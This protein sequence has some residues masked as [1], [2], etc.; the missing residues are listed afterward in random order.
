M[1]ARLATLLGRLERA[2]PRARPAL[3]RTLLARGDPWEA[4][5]APLDRLHTRAPERELALARVLEAEARRAHDRP[6]AARFALVGARALHRAGAPREAARALGRAARL[7]ARSGEEGLALKAR[8]LGVDALA[9]A[10]RVADALAEAR[11][12]R[13]R[14]GGR[15]RR[16]W[17]A[18]LAVNE[19]AALRLGGRVGEARQGFERAARAFDALGD[20]HSA[21]IARTNA[22][23]ACLDAGDG[24]GARRRLGRAIAAF[25]A[26]GQPDMLLDARENLC[27]AQALEGAL[28]EAIRGL[29][30]LVAEQ[31]RRGL[32]RRAA[33]ARMDLADVLRRAGDRRAAARSARRAA[34]ELRRL[35]ARAEEVE[36]LWQ[37][38][39]AE[40]DA[41]V[42]RRLRARARRAARRAARPGIALRCELLELDAALA[43]GRPP[44]AAA[45]THLGA[46]ARRA[47][48]E[49]LAREAEVLLGQV[50]WA[51]GRAGAAAQAWRAALRGAAGRPWIRAAAET[52]LALVAAGRG[53]TG[54]AL[55]RLRRVARFLDAVRH[56]LPGPWLR[57]AFVLQQ[58]DP[59]LLRVDLLLDRGRPAD[60]REAAALLGALGARR[61]LERVRPAPVGPEAA[62]RRRLEAIYD[63]L[64][65]GEGP[66]RGLAGAERARLV[67]EARALE[68]RVADAWRGAERAQ[69]G[70]RGVGLARPRRRRPAPGT[71][72]LHLW[73]RHGEVRGLW[74]RRERIGRPVGLGAARGLGEA[75][76]RVD[77]HAERLRLL[78]A[79]ADP[80]PLGAE[81]GA[82]AARWLPGLDAGN[83]PRRVH[84]ARDPGVPDLPLE[85]LPGPAGPL[86]LCHDLLRVPAPALGAGRALAARGVCVVAL[87]EADL[88]ALVRELGA[89]RGPVER[90]EGAGAT[91]AALQAA[92]RTRAVVHVAGHGL[93]APEAPPLGGIRV[94]DG[95]FAAADVPARVGARLVVLSACRTGLEQGAAGEAWGGLPAALL[96]AG[97][98]RVLYTTAEVDD[99]AAARL[100]VA[101][102]A[103]RAGRTAERAFGGAL[104]EV[105][106]R[107]GHPGR[108]LPFR[109]A[110]V[111]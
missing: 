39:Q 20:R 36:A 97:A 13:P 91:R 92:L 16:A 54:A 65:R 66:L 108:L 83:W 9:H 50:A 23:V 93:D 53:E 90:I 15:T 81:L 99:D 21:A 14:L 107:D 87:G 40:P 82:L 48:E 70:A 51:A 38:A 88:P 2:T 47:G 3:A 35:G 63:R 75:L 28:G 72:V 106:G 44:P 101:F 77:F 84:V 56:D 57:T 104:A 49:G 74:E 68:R 111:A 80:A 60:R 52:G 25:E 61:F 85:L 110:G 109:L 59:H 31:E 58:L 45:L 6:L 4:W 71:L 96:A 26:L 62:L 76:E 18:A 30:G 19:A 17:R 10:G 46:R 67:R 55:A 100:A 64:A 5:Q 24:A 102:H 8:V 7:L 37:A 73:L 79:R 22:A 42:R 12:L 1:A 11:R 33:S 89:V 69:A 86:A 95:W 43:A 103:R 94:S 105:A 78:G 27:C 32:R 29:E 98:R 41:A 34:D